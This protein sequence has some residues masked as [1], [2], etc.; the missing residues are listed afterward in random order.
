[1]EQT[2]LILAN[3]LQTQAVQTQQQQTAQTQQQGEEEV[4]FQD[5]M[6]EKVQAVD[7]GDQAAA[8]GDKDAAQGETAS[9][10]EVKP[11]K[12]E[13]PKLQKGEEDELIRQL[14]C[15]QL[16]SG[17]A[18]TQ[19]QEVTAQTAETV[20]L[21]ELQPIA[22]ELEPVEALS[23]EPVSE[24]QPQTVPEQPV[25]QPEAVSQSQVA[26]APQ[27]AEPVAAE[28]AAETAE[29]PQAQPTV[30]TP[31]VQTPKSQV[32]VSENVSYD[33]SEDDGVPQ[34]QTVT[35]PVS[36]Q[37]QEKKDDGQTS[38]DLPQ[39]SREDD[40]KVRVTDVQTDEPQPLFTTVEDH[41]IKVG[42]TAKTLPGEQTVDA[43]DVN[44]QVAQSVTKALDQG[45][46]KVELQLQPES[47]G[48]VTVEV[49]EQKDGSLQVVLTAENS[50][51]RQIL[52][53][54]MDG[55]RDLLAGQSQKPVE[56]QVPRQ[57]NGGDKDAAYDGRH[58]GQQRE[59][60]EQRR[61]QEKQSGDDFLQQLR[62]G[63]IPISVNA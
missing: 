30:E 47:L 16:L 34:V 13:T 60:E 23:A 9:K 6:R 20:Q 2:D 45:E 26:Q 22:A 55:L 5:L 25:V 27:A 4:D 63:L 33:A 36:V 19:T 42:D 51:T 41:M 17:D 38:A 53:Q 21:P 7:S 58:G 15:A 43:Q 32:S 37:P 8:A 59:Q 31:K 11:E 18:V 35:A 14:A 24:V 50:H 48:K 1:L 29:L 52:G 12:T 54:H 10:A 56:I 46:T 44:D 3:L 28:T 39:Q 49:T 57:E 62:L 40:G 61:Q